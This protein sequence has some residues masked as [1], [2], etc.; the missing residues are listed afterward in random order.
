MSYIAASAPYPAAGA[1]PCRYGSRAPP[2]PL[3]HRMLLPPPVSTIVVMV[4]SLED[5]RIRPDDPE[6]IADLVKR[7]AAGEREAWDALVRRFNGLIWA[8]VRRYRLSPAD[9][10]DV[11][12][13]VWLRL[14]ENLGSLRDPSRVSGWLATTTR[15]ECLRLIRLGHRTVPAT[16]DVLERKSDP[17]AS[18]ED[19]VVASDHQRAVFKIVRMLELRCRQL[20]ELSAYHLPY[21]AI[22]EL[23]DMPIGS[24]G[25]TRGR[26]L[27]QLRVLLR[28]AG[29]NPDV[30]DS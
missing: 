28:A 14:L 17:S 4:V 5:G 26:C 13:V 27:E 9:S 21:Q 1:Q 20:L 29:I 7:A 10:Q 15:H 2:T 23:L 11:T 3:T 12:Q 18:P 22:S 19:I 16:D 30:R 8:I 25:P 24:I 6:E